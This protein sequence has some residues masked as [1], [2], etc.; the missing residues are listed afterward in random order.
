MFE[1]GQIDEEERDLL[2]NLGFS[3]DKYM[4]SAWD[5]Y[6]ILFDEDDLADTFLVIIQVIRNKNNDIEQEQ[7]QEKEEELQLNVSNNSQQVFDIDPHF[8]E[9]EQ[10]DLF[11]DEIQEDASEYNDDIKGIMQYQHKIL[12]KYAM[13]GMI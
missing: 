1:K 12:R 7:E 13:L 8:Q 11:I 3:N 10:E 4:M 9:E 6:N 2:R 5:T